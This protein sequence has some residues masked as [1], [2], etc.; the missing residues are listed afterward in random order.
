MKHLK[1][2]TIFLLPQ[3]ELYKKGLPGA[4][5]RVE[6][7]FGHEGAVYCEYTSVPGIAMGDG[8]GWQN[9][10]NYRIRG[11]EIPFG[12]PRANAAMGFRDPVEKGIM[13]NGALAYHWESQVEHAYMILEYQ[14][15][16]GEDISEFMPFIEQ[17]LIFFD[18]HYRLGQKMRNRKELDENGKL[19]I[20][21]D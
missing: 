18:K 9:D 1:R 3:F 5:A 6:K 15:F 8:W 13:T 4:A 20:Y 2:N 16:T 17:S 21:P 14:R 12:D 19:V 7:N 10:Y 11:E